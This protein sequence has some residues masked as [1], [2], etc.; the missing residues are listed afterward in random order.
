MPKPAQVVDALR[1]KSG[2]AWLIMAEAPDIHNTQNTQPP[3]YFGVTKHHTI[4][5]S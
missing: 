4:L 5:V 2:M 3:F 1:L